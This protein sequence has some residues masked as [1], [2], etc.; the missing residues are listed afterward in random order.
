M[1]RSDA[2]R[3]RF[4]RG[5]AVGLGVTV[6]LV[7]VVA[8]FGMWTLIIPGA[9]Q[10]FCTAGLELGGAVPTPAPSPV[11]DEQAILFDPISTTSVS[12]AVNVSTQA[13]V[14]GYGAAFLVNALSTTGY[15]YQVGVAYDWGWNSGYLPGFAFIYAMFAPGE[16]TNAPTALCM[17][18]VSLQSGVPVG[19]A[20]QM[21]G[22]TVL[23]SMSDPSGSLLDSVLLGAQGAFG[24]VGA[25]NATPAGFFTGWMTEWRHAAAYYGP[26]ADAAY[27][28]TPNQA[29]ADFGIG[30]YDASTGHTLFGQ[31]SD[32]SL[33]CGCEQ[34]FSYEGVS[35]TAGASVFTTG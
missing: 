26:T 25:S 30:E 35:E 19:L 8:G 1:A 10:S 33:A 4:R 17:E 14:N 13:D 34:S 16:G 6:G 32:Q 2:D 7:V 15:W 11:Y 24:F 3:R 9:A 22:G 21:N 18:R 27:S 20:I 5:V 29:S 31:E 28:L 23:L 12:S